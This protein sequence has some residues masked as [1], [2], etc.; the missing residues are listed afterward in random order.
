MELM[1]GLADTLSMNPSDIDADSK[2]IDLGLDS[3]TG[4]E[5][6]QAINREYGTS[7]P[8][9]KVYDYPSIREFAH[10]LQKELTKQEGEDVSVPVE[11]VPA[12]PEESSVLHSSDLSQLTNS[13]EFP[14]LVRLNECVEGRPVFW[15]HGGAGEIGGYRPIA[16]KI[17]RP[18]YGIQP[19]GL[20]T[21]HSPIH[22]V[23][24]MATYYLNIIRSVQ[25]EGP[26]DLG[27]FSFAG[28]LAYEVTRLLQE[29]GETV[30]TIV[31]VDSIYMEAPQSAEA[32][33]EYADPKTLMLQA[34]NRELL[35]KALL[36]QEKLPQALIHREEVNIEADDETFLQQ[37][38][39]LAKERGL[40]KSEKE[41]YDQIRKEVKVQY[42]Y[43]VERY[44]LSPLPDP[45]TVSCY[46][47]RNKSGEFYGELEPYFTLKEGTNP[48]D[49][50][51]YWQEWE[52]HLPNFHLMDVESSNHIMLLAEPKAYKTIAAFCEKL[53]SV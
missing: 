27:G 6:I 17:N 19:R 2:F 48:F 35:A 22:G 13:P 44:S 10:F 34:V 30:N 29:M 11:S 46:Y 45:L 1:R 15:F 14:E 40:K 3:I 18:F 52:K 28:R 41:M 9:S 16:R 36:E 47:F 12:L 39:T 23:Y 33:K 7:I 37:L 26:Y 31:M 20:T 51:K 24:A 38:I 32:K 4:V 49:H 8:A 50:A 5:W 42:A 53:Y 43:E 25:P 21:D